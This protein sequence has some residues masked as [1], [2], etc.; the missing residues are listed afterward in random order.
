MCVKAEQAGLLL[1][2]LGAGL[3]L[4]F[5]LGGWFLQVLVAVVLIV[6]GLLLL[7]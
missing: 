3:L 5:V 4:S 6:L 1:I 2:G 7:K